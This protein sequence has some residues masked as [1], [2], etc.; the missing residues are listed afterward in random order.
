LQKDANIYAP[1]AGKINTSHFACDYGHYMEY[2]VERVTGGE[3]TVLMTIKNAKCWY[4]CR[5][6]AAPED[7]RYTATTKDSL[8]GQAMRTGDLLCVG[9]PGT[10][11]TLY[12]INTIG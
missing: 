6:K 3:A 7:G 5:N 1:A 11:I 9:Q 2:M 4:C 10:T 12:R 8:K